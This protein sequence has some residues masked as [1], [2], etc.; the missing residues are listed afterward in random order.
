ALE[1]Q[2]YDEAI[3]RADQHLH[4]SPTGI[5]SSEALYL[6]GRGLEQKP[7]VNAQEAQQNLLQARDAYNQALAQQPAANLEPLVRAGIAN[8][9]YW[10]NDYSTAMQQ[11]NSAYNSFDDA[12]T[13]SFILYR[14]GLCQ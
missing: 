12:A 14:I 3:A 8:T 7:A 2:Q 1:Q 6:K 11:W 13:K 10:L 9:S 4:D 5:G